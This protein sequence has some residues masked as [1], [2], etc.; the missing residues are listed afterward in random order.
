MDYIESVS[1][2]KVARE[3]IIK[4]ILTG[5]NVINIEE[6]NVFKGDST[7][8]EIMYAYLTAT[9]KYLEFNDGTTS[10]DIP[11]EFWVEPEEAED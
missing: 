9:G 1:S 2:N 8:R 3:N 4:E 6:L 5:K 11:E 10:V 7:T